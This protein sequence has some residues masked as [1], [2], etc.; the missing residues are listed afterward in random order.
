VGLRLKRW[1]SFLVRRKS[2]FQNPLPTKKKKNT[3]FTRENQQT[4]KAKKRE[5]TEQK[6]YKKTKGELGK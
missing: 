6:F 1:S 5:R 4:R 2:L 3:V